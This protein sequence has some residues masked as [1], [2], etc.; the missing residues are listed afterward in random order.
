MLDFSRDVYDDFR[1]IYALSGKIFSRFLG[2]FLVSMDSL[3]PSTHYANRG[4][5]NSTLRHETP[6]ILCSL[7][8]P[9]V[10]I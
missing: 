1:D 4:I 6:N 3:I 8:G 5:I 7:V 9:S 10:S 2:Q